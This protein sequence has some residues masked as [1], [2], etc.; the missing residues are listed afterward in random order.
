MEMS[1]SIMMPSIWKNVF[2]WEASVLSLRKQR[3]GKMA[4]S[5]APY[6]F[7]MVFCAAEVWVFNS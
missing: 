4:R 5:G 3:P 2:S 1:L 6:F 7:M